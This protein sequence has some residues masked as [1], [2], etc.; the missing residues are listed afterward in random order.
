MAVPAPRRSQRKRVQPNWITSGEFV[1]A[2][3]ATE[4]GSKDNASVLHHLIDLQ[5]DFQ[6][7]LIDS[8]KPH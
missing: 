2:Q 4:S 3:V 5:I 8:L 7:T 1:C 6:K